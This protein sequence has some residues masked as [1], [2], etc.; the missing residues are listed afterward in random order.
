MREMQADDTCGDHDFDYHI[1]PAN[2]HINMLVVLKDMFT[3]LKIVN[4]VHRPNMVASML[5]T[6]MG[7]FDACGK[8]ERG[9]SLS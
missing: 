5:F 6:A 8:A 9:E 3:I 4:P 2:R 1:R 7:I